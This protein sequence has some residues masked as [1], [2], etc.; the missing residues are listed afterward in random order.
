[1]T[2]DVKSPGLPF[3]PSPGGGHGTRDL[4]EDIADRV[5]QKLAQPAHEQVV[6]PDPLDE[7][8]V[9]VISAFTPEMDPAYDAIVA[10]ARTV[11]LRA[12]RVKDVK[13][14]YRIT[15]KILAMI[16]RARFIVADLTHDRPNV[17]FERGYARG[18]G[19]T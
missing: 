7:K 2:L 12:E 15:E 17:Y 11:G 16:R 13:G 3:D 6:V 8:L 10:A 19:K 1:M 9:F 4:A 5:I 18:L 14:D